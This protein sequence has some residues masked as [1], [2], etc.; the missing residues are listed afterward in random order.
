M[1]TIKTILLPTDGSEC[2]SRAMAYARSFAKW[3]A[4]APAP[5]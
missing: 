4:G 2:S 3:S 1:I 5:S